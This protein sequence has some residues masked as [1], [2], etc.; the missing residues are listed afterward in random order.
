MVWGTNRTGQLGY[1]KKLSNVLRPIMYGGY[2]DLQMCC[3]ELLPKFGNKPV[4]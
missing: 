1:P 4:G 2:I 3:P